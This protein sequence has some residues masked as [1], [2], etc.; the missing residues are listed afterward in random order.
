MTIPVAPAK[1]SARLSRGVSLW[2]FGNDAMY[3]SVMFGI[4]DFGIFLAACVALNLTPGPDTIYILG[5]GIAQGRGAAV[6]SVLGISSG[7]LVHTLGAALGLSAVLAAS[8]S[9]F[10]FIK[11]A[12]ACYL[13]YLGI[14]M[15]F[16]GASK[17]AIPSSFSTSGFLAVYRQGL[18][19][20]V[21]NPKVALFFLAFVPQFITAGNPNKFTAFLVLGSCFI[22]SG[23]LW[24]LC[25]AWF[26]A[27]IGDKL[28]R[29]S[30]LS[31]ILNRVTGALFVGLGI[32]LAVS[33]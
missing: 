30:K 22:V 9:A 8:A 3:S 31:E 11:L 32:R 19:T 29:S 5:R 12:G 23:T 18:L 21:L 15:L 20:N 10:L 16:R 27:A 17:A 2:R 7:G 28:R 14:R 1:F 4:H 6:A 24:C 26:S 13:I 25:L 33:E